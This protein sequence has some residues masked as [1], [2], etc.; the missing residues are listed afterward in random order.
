MNV[1]CLK[2]GQGFEIRGG[3]ILL[4]STASDHL[5]AIWRQYKLE[6]HDYVYTWLVKALQRKSFIRGCSKVLSIISWNRKSVPGLTVA[7]T[8]LAYK[9]GRWFLAPHSWI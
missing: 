4:H 9:S 1:F 7:A 3:T 5:S 6:W 8:G 2:Q